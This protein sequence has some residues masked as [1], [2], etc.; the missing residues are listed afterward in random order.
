M[1][2]T[3]VKGCLHCGMQLPDSAD[4]CPECGRSVEVVILS[5]SKVKQTGTTSTTGCLHCGLGLPDSVDFCPE[6]GRPI[7]RGLIPQAT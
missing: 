5:D 4:F 1:R 7:E 2:T 3:I 6:C